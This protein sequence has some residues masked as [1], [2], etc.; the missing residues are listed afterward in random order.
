MGADLA[1]DGCEAGLTLVRVRFAFAH[2]TCT[3]PFF[4]RIFRAAK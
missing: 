4:G 2:Q 1:R 3:K